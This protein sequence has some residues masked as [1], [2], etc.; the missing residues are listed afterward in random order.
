MDK[1]KSQITELERYSRLLKRAEES[2]GIGHWHLDV[3]ANT[4]FW[5]DEIYRIHGMPNDGQS[6]NVE[7]AI[8]AYH[9]DDRTRVSDAVSQAIEKGKDFN[10]ELRLVRPDGE[11]RYVRSTGECDFD[12]N[13]N[14]VGVFGIFSDI[15]DFKQRELEFEQTNKKL[16]NI[17]SLIP[18][19]VFVKD[20]NSVIIEANDKFLN[21]YP[22]N[23]RD[24]II[25]TT[26]VE[27]HDPEEAKLFLEQDRLAIEKG[28]TQTVEDIHF[29]NGE[30]R[31]LETK[32]VGFS[33]DEGNRFLL[34][35]GR[36]VTE[37]LMNEK[38]YKS[39][40][41]TSGNGFITIDNNSNVLT[42]NSGAEKMFGYDEDEVVGQNLK[43]LMPSSTA[44]HHDDYIS[45]YEQT[46]DKKIIGS[47]CEVVGKRKNGTPVPLFLSVDELYVG[48]QRFY[49]GILQD[50]TEKK[51][52]EKALA[53]SEYTREAF[54]D[55]S[56]DGYWDWLVKDD[57]QYMSPRF[58]TMMGYDP[59]TKKHHPS[60]WQECIFPEDLETVWNN[61]NIHAESKG[62]IP[63]VQEVRYKKADGSTLWVICKGQI[64]EWDHTGQPV[65][66]IGTHTDITA[67]KQTQEELIESNMELER[68][69]YIA[70][71]DL[72][73]P[74]RMVAS[75]TNL[76][77]T[78]YND[79]LDD[80]ARSYIKYATDAAERMRE[81][82]ND[83]LDYS[84]LGHHD[85]EYKEI[86]ALDKV[87]L[88]CQ[89]IDGLI[90]ERDVQ[91]THDS[92]PCIYFNPLQ[93][94]QLMQNLI[95]N[96]IKYNQNTPK[97]HIG[98]I[99]RDD[100]YE[101]SVSDNGIGISTDYY[102]KIFDI[103]E[104]LHGAREYEGTGIGLAI[105]KKIVENAGGEIWVTSTKGKGTTFFFT[106]PK[107]K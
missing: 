85:M 23:Q 15:T 92:L 54:A 65:R 50:L 53:D 56:S 70:S 90:K 60:E 30:R 83:L 40:L 44:R 45:R 89:Y 76:L 34:G 3:L 75:F 71:H 82:V 32:K 64:V 101:F 31:V 62:T 103:F 52:I 55:S 46:G 91:I 84:R 93:F 77:A 16:A 106:V 25:G 38:I 48:D 102:D 74:L 107:K 5:S 66:M 73:E 67:L 79:Q 4:L 36:D 69:A 58:W 24:S 33:D 57:Y 9:P 99:E 42:F 18:D 61:Y 49:A 10:F 22:E 1:L 19:A 51:K 28:F 14:V 95:T 68:F 98:C 78:Q 12:D 35:I 39:I 86:H 72:Q 59:E 43:M 80:K 17:I 20:E 41:N 47:G 37:I 81:L 6:I 8:E 97:I 87:N 29:P 100:V 94:T 7:K 105:C 26:A 2:A 21:L 11:I 104:R 88:V 63:F 96:G 27:D 13:N